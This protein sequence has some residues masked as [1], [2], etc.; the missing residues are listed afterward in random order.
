VSVDAQQ[1][2]AKFV[3]ND[4]KF[5]LK[6]GEWSDWVVVRYSLFPYLAEATGICRFFLKS[7][8]QRFALYVTPINIDPSNPALPI[9]TPPDYSKRLVRDIGYFYTQGMIE[10]TNALSS[11][12]LNE[13]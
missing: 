4:S 9:S 13:A 8:R 5:I 1:G 7:A 3:V 6:E 10:D 12:V 2:A 11:G